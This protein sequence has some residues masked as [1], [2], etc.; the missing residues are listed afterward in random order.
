MN[1]SAINIITNS[2]EPSSSLYHVMEY[3]S[4][5]LCHTKTFHMEIVMENHTKAKET[6]CYT[7]SI[8]VCQGFDDRES[9]FGKTHQE[10]YYTLDKL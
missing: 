9:V 7:A 3:I 4:L 1:Y 8:E 5:C 10:K 6:S 2:S